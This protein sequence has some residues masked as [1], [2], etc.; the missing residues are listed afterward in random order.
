MGQ[1]FKKIDAAFYRSTHGAEPVRDWLM[2]LSA[3]DRRM[4]G[5]DIATVEFG[6]PVGMPLC[7][8]LGEGLWEVRSRLTHGKIAR[9][10]FCIAHGR[11]I[12]LHGFV[13]KTQKMPKTDLDT[14]RK[15][16]KEVEQ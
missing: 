11:M 12:L 13:K 7:R 5:Y 8:P 3:E 15:R 6:W 16:Q 2:D 4:I 14:A 9:V 10:V 1:K